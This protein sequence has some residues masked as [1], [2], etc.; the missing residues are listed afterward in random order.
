[1]HLSIIRA[2]TLF[3]CLS[4]GSTALGMSQ[5]LENILAGIDSVPTRSQLVEALGDA[6][7]QLE[8]VAIDQDAPLYHRIRATS[9]LST[10][11]EDG[12]RAAL[13]RLCSNSNVEIRRHAVY[14]LLR[15]TRGALTTNEWSK[16]QNM[17]QADD[18][19]VQKDIIRGFRWSQDQR[20]VEALRQI[21]SEVGPLKSLA[22]HVL[23]RRA[24]LHKAPLQ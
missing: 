21:G 10:V 6:S 12:G 17:L 3:A 4:I 15:S 24:V 2:T 5:P 23:N 14:G 22:V 13:L 9:M 18:P 7:A 11:N 20:G 16:I 19:M 1:M 8:S